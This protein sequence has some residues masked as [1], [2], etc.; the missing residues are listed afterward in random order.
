MATLKTNS[1]RASFTTTNRHHAFQLGW[2]IR[3]TD[4]AWQNPVEVPLGHSN[5][6][7]FSPYSVPNLRFKCSTNGTCDNDSP[8]TISTKRRA[9]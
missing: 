5:S 7:Q 8:V 3:G 6:S 2:Q 4:E 1:K 9:G